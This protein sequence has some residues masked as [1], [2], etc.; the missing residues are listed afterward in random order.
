MTQRIQRHPFLAIFDGAD[1][2]V[3]TALR[4]VST[5]PL[6]AL[7]FL[8][9]PFVHE[10]AKGFAQRIIATSPDTLER[11]HATY[12]Q[13]LGR[14]PSKAEAELSQRLLDSINKS[15]QSDSLSNAERESEAWQSLIRGIFRLNEFVYID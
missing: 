8:N 7:Y 12:R 9:D 1:P 4:P 15:L 3:S 2:A 11:L 6:Q 5:T 10:Q 14:L 13:A